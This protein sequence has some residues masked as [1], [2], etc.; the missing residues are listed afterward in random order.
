MRKF[1]IASTLAF[2]SVTGYSQ[3]VIF[4]VKGG[5]NLASFTANYYQSPKITPSFHV[6]G[7]AN[8]I[9]TDHF[10]LQPE[11]FYSGKGGK[12][13]GGKMNLGYVNIPVLAQYKTTSGFFVEAGP[14][15]GLLI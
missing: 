5:L 4:G 9:L 14:Q 3:F 11:V 13:T 15:A 2:L 12:F 6:G 10:M 1:L 7:L 8:F